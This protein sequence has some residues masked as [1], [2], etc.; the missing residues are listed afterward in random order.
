MEYRGRNVALDFDNDTGVRTFIILDADDREAIPDGVPCITESCKSCYICTEEFAWHPN[1]ETWREEGPEWRVLPIKPNC[2]CKTPIC[3]GCLWQWLREKKDIDRFD[4][5]GNLI[6]YESL[7]GWFNC[8]NCRAVTRRGKFL[9]SSDEYYLPLLEEEEVEVE[10]EEEEEE[11]EETAIPDMPSTGA[12]TEEY[13]LVIAELI[14][15][16]MEANKKKAGLKTKLKNSER[17]RKALRTSNKKLRDER[18]KNE[19][20]KRRREDEVAS[21]GITIEPA[22]KKKPDEEPLDLD[23]IDD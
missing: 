14:G 21:S 6:G 7:H 3:Y 22:R 23:D 12:S 2:R 16:L 18:K 15:M 8:P 11:E 1:P 17:A 9:L 5:E 13:Q 10:E 20:A 4:Q 19:P